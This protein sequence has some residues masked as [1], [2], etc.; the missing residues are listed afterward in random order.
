[1]PTSVGPKIYGKENLVFGYDLGDT[2]N[3]FKGK[4]ATNHLTRITQQYSDYDET[5]FKITNGSHV[6]DVPQL[7]RRTVKYVDVWNDYN[8]GSGQCC[9]S[10]FTFGTGITSVS[11]NTTYTYQII[12]KTDTG[13][14]N[15]NYMYRYEYGAAGYIRE[16]GLHSTGRRT[17]LGD[18]WYHAWGTVTLHPDTTYINTYLFHYEYA[19]QNRVQVAAVMFT[20]GTE[21]IPPSQFLEVEE[22]RS[23]VQGLLDITGNSTLD[24]SNVSFD[25]NAQMEF[26]GTDDRISIPA[27]AIPTIGTSDFT[28]EF[29]CK[30]TKTSSY[31]HFFSVKDQYHFSFKASNSSGILYAYRTSELST[32]NTIEAY[33]PS[34]TSYYHIVLKRSGDSLEIFINGVSQGTKS[35]WDNAAIENNLYT[36]YIGWGNASEYTGGEIPIAKIYNRALL[37]SE[38]QSN[39]NAIKGRFNIQ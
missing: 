7:G 25:S 31:N 36:S 10:L 1:M 19:T 3:S 15:T 29:V 11:G 33:I 4:P 28:M 9:L 18:G 23:N 5:Y 26:D 2:D 35:G 17:H 20:E 14:S 37:A 38:V 21:I 6:V 8:S 24:I 16:G 13:Y 27:G 22:T 34:R 30:N 12:Y 39:F 32:T